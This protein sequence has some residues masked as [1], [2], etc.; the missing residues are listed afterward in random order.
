MTKE[1]KS[2]LKNKFI[3]SALVLIVQFVFAGA[4]AESVQM[5]SQDELMNTPGKLEATEMQTTSKAP[6]SR[7]ERIIRRNVQR[8]IQ[9]LSQQ[10]EYIGLHARNSKGL[11]PAAGQVISALEAN[12]KQQNLNYAEVEENYAAG[13]YLLVQMKQFAKKL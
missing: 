11:L 3:I 2:I 13:S 5:I 9:A 4:H 8:L 12:L 10:Q 7:R 1:K 6:K